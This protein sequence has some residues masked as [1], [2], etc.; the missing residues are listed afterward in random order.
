MFEILTLVC[1][2]SGSGMSYI[3]FI[4]SLAAMKCSV[5]FALMIL[6]VLLSCKAAPLS[7]NFPL[8]IYP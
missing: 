1:V 6:F 4:E 8:Y 2:L 5:F 7:C 3:D